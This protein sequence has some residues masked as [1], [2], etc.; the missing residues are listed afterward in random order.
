[1]LTKI[2]PS[3]GTFL[4]NAL[5]VAFLPGIRDAVAAG[6]LGSLN[7]IPVVMQLISTISWSNYGLAIKNPYIALSNVPA[8]VLSMWAVASVLPLIKDSKQLKTV[9]NL[10]VG[11]TAAVIG[12]WT[13]LVFAVNPAKMGFALGAAA[14]AL[15]IILFASPLTALSE[16]ISQKDSSSIYAP[17]AIVQT[18]NCLMWFLYGLKIWDYWVFGPNATGLVLALIQLA[19]LAIFPSKSAANND[20][21]GE[22]A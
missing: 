17:F 1:M 6:S 20:L 9:K 10:L 14:T 11:G 5:Y 18:A 21:K 4:S 19:L 7:P 22:L 3:F 8:V 15:C 16:V 2:I 12:L 13:T